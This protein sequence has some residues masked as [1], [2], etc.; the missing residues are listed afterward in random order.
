M[1]STLSLI[2]IFLALAG[3]G[4]A[5]VWAI[6]RN[7][8]QGERY[9][10]RLL[11]RL[12]RLRLGGA[13]PMFGIKPDE[14]L[15]TQPIVDIEEHMRLCKSCDVTES[16]DDALENRRF[17]DFPSCVNYDSLQ[18]ISRSLKQAAVQES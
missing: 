16:C 1:F 7:L 8:R 15:H 2:V 17:E 6:V 9:R 13:L 4:A 3:T 14:Y 11:K 12:K 10:Q 5:I 18:S